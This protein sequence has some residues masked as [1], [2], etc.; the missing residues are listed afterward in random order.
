MREEKGRQ[1]QATP[2]CLPAFL[3]ITT[4]QS[5]QT[6]LFLSPTL[7]Q[8]T[9]SSLLVWWGHLG[10]FFSRNTG[11]TGS[12]RRAATSTSQ[13]QG[14]V[15]PLSGTEDE[16]QRRERRPDVVECKGGREERAQRVRHQ[17]EDGPSLQDLHEG[18]AEQT[19]NLGLLHV[20]P[21]SRLKGSAKVVQLNVER[22]GL[23][24]G[25]GSSPAG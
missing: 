22:C 5:V 19:R 17:Q 23:L 9:N 18:L 13:T 8:S 21:C 4:S 1:S 24:N 20:Q 2:C 11:L 3:R 12:A 25:D 15:G 10:T 16:R 14:P 7:H 6:S